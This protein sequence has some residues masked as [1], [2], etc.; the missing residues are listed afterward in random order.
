MLRSLVIGLGALCL[1]GGLIALLAGFPFGIVVMIGGTAVL[2]GTFYERV[3]YKP[4]VKAKPGPDW[5]RTSER[6]YDDQTGKLLTVY[7]QP[8]TGERSYVEE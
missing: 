3:L 2:V 8:E 6:F 4:A 5:T 7:I 1:L